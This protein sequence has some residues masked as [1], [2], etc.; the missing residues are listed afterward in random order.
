LGD[1]LDLDR[2]K[3]I[4][5]FAYLGEDELGSGEIGLKRGRVP[6]GMIALVAL[7]PSK[8]TRTELVD[9]LRLQADRFGKPIAPCRFALAEVVTVIRP[10]GP[11]G[12]R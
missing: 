11:K 3:G 10:S 4:E 2:L 7:D 5:L 12:G 1:D 6:A 9:Q 8:L